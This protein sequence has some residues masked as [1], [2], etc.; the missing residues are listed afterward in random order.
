MAHSTFSAVFEMILI[1]AI[2]HNG[3][4]EKFS[5]LGIPMNI[6]K[7][8]EQNINSNLILIIDEYLDGSAITIGL[9]TSPGPDWLKD[10]VSK[11]GLRLK[12]HNAL[13]TLYNESQ[14]SKF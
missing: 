1:K 4:C 8:H 10:V 6:I 2:F 7:S 5:I 12:V 13:R 14:V 11:I 9:S 3:H